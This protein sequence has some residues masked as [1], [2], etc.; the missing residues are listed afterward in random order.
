[1]KIQAKFF[2]VYLDKHTLK[3]IWGI[4]ATNIAKIISKKQEGNTSVT[5]FIE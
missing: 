3:F 4:A 2:F 5:A 1:M